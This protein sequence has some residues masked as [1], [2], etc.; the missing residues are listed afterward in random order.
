MSGTNKSEITITVRNPLD[1]A[2]QLEY[3]IVPDKHLL[4]KDWVDALKKTLQDNKFLEKNFCFMGFPKTARTL[5][6]LCDQL[7]AHVNTINLFSS[8]V[9]TGNI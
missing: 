5:E 7:N 9:Q 4:A 2:D 3:V 1:H 8:T 6:Y